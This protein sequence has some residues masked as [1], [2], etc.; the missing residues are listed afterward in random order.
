[1]KT[2]HH[3]SGSCAAGGESSSWYAKLG[4]VKASREEIFISSFRGGAKGREPGIHSHRHSRSTRG[5]SSAMSVVI[6]SGLAASRRPGM[7]RAATPPHPNPL[8]AR[9]ERESQA[10]RGRGK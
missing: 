2:G 7:T 6:D 4:R 3:F 8:P 1:P 9:G 10:R 5:D